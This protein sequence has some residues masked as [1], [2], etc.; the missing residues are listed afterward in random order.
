MDVSKSL[1]GQ[2]K[3]PAKLKKE[4]IGQQYEFKKDREVC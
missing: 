2:R 1:K 4:T 3:K